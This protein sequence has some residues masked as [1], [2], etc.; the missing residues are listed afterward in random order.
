MTKPTPEQLRFILESGILAPSADN[1]HPLRFEV[2]ED[3]VN[4]WYSRGGLPEQGGYKR[5]LV[6]L[7]M[8]A[9]SENLTLAAGRYGLHVE[10]ELFPQPEKPNLVFRIRWL[11]GEWHD[12]DEAS[13]WEVIP[14]R[15]TNRSIRYRGP[16]LSPQEQDRLERLAEAQPGVGLSWL[17]EPNVRRKALALMRLAEGERF[18]NPVL[19]QELFSAIRFDTGWR[20]PCDDGLPPGALGVEPP[21][22]PAFA[23]LRHWRV[24]RI[25]NLIGGYRAL[26]WRVADLPS[27]FAPHLAVISIRQ[28]D[29]AGIFSAGR[30][31]QRLWLAA[32]Q[33]GLAVQPM[34]AS[35]LY[36][37]PGATRESVQAGLQQRLQQ[38]WAGMVSGQQPVMLFRLG[39]A[40]APAITAGRKPLAHYLS[41]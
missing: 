27:R 16:R 19:H 7:S 26:G 36:A 9:V 41:A 29:D 20:K 6:L 28:P 17:D 34:P 30:A 37:W 18:R 10:P 11:P 40:P 5:V 32:T 12:Q 22:R 31:F 25:V 21:L 14:L 24:M 4:I 8:G 35:A 33:S 2:D 38:G 23:L 39:G 15:H 3:G 13:L 1:H